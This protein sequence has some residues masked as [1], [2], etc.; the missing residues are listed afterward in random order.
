[1][2]KS[3]GICVHLFSVS[4]GLVGVCLTVI[5]LIRVAGESSSLN[6]DFLTGDALG[7]LICCLLSYAALR[8]RNPRMQAR[9]ERIADYV[10]LC[11]MLVMVIICATITYQLA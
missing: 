6:D 1:M 4:A 10:F 9:L 7:F 3:S 8:S 11:C 5:G 2:D